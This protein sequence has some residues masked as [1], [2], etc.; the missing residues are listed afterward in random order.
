[1]AAAS[2]FAY[3]DMELVKGKS[4]YVL[5]NA[6]LIES[7]YGLREDL[8]VLTAAAELGKIT[9][10]VIQEDLQDEETL[11]LLL[12]GLHFLEQRKRRPSLIKAVFAIRLLWIQGMIS[13]IERMN[14]GEASRLKP[15]TKA[16]YDY[17]CT[18]EE[19]KL[20][21]FKLSEEVEQELC[22]HADSL[23]KTILG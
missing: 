6:K 9:L 13:S 19:D 22:N 12:K 2:V 11:R 7:F 15:G 4:M 3:S 5:K 14:P 21:A 18:A 17:I 10:K 23:C 1:L 16:A 8:D 20:F